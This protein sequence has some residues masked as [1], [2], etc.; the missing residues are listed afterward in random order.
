[1]R[2]KVLRERQSDALCFI[3]KIED[4]IPLDNPL[5]N[6]AE[7]LLATLDG[8]TVDTEVNRRLQAKHAERLK[9][10]VTA[11]KASTLETYDRI[12]TRRGETARE[13]PA[14]EDFPAGSP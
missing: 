3:W 7:K 14:D 9:L 8:Q 2:A 12:V 13:A 6:N 1:M 11:S 5:L 10:M 4:G